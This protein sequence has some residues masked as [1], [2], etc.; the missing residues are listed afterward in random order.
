MAEEPAPLICPACQHENPPA[1]N[2]GV[3]QMRRRTTLWASVISL[4]SVAGLIGLTSTAYAQSERSM[5][6]EA[7]ES[8]MSE[9]SNWGRWGDD[10][11]LGTINLITASK[12]Q[13]AAALV[14]EGIAVSLAR[15]IS[16]NP[17][18]DNPLPMGHAV[19]VTIADPRSGDLLFPD[20]P[21]EAEGW[22]TLAPAESL[23]GSNDTLTMNYHGFAYTH[24]D[25]LCHIFHNGKMYNGF[26][27]TTVTAQ[28]AG[29]LDIVK[30]KQGIFT[31]GVLFDIPRLKGIPYLEPGTP[32]LPEDLDAWE[33]RAGVKVE[34]GDAVL[35]RTGR[36]ARRAAEGP[37]DVDSLGSAG[38]HPTVAK[39]L[40]DRGAALVGSDSGTGLIPYVVEGVL[41]PFH[42]LAIVAMGMPIIDNA[43]LEKLGE[44]ANRLGRWEFLLTAAPLAV[45]GGTG[46]P[47]NPIAT[48]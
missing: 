30:L 41:I 5:T 46:S 25:A 39:W 48:F 19:T 43:D 7:F 18:P 2:I 3:H 31:R 20:A 13:Q 40:R 8:L 32:V 15:D 22:A 33:E 35:I 12:R 6:P 29:K 21:Q 34:P 36:W 11:Q 45:P 16:K 26:S 42:K 14:R 23:L 28:G 4:V 37:W 1:L 44:E 27:P 17:A 47:L 9:V 24:I 38:P 10:D